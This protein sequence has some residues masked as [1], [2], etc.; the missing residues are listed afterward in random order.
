M[1]RRL[2]F[3]LAA[4]SPGPIARRRRGVQF[5][6]ALAQRLLDL[7]AL[8]PG[9]VVAL[10]QPRHAARPA[11]LAG[12]AQRV[13]QHLVD[14]RD[15]T[16]LGREKL[17]LRRAGVT[18]GPPQSVGHAKFPSVRPAADRPPLYRP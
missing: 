4:I 17:P 3:L 7:A 12:P 1:V 8:E 16:G 11:D 10:D 9:L 2:S 13:V 15:Q 18:D 14:G 6:T 5:V